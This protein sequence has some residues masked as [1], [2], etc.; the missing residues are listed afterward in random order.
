MEQAYTQ[1]KNLWDESKKGKITQ[2]T[3]LLHMKSDV[4]LTSSPTSA[5]DMSAEYPERPPRLDW[6]PP[7][8]NSAE[9]IPQ[10]FVKTHRKSNSFSSSSPYSSTEGIDGPNSA[11]DQRRNSIGDKAVPEKKS[12]WWTHRKTSSDGEDPTIYNDD[13]VTPQI[14]ESKSELFK[15]FFAVPQNEKLLQSM[16]LLSFLTNLNSIFCIIYESFA[17]AWKVICFNELHM[18]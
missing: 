7:I 10:A 14:T 5:V 2:R 15:S 13:E 16:I 17:I 3:R 4:A 1:L 8:S 11:D 9:L 12:S 6:T 18:L